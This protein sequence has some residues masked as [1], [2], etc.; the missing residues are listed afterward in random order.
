MRRMH[1]RLRGGGLIAALALASPHGGC[2][3]DGTAF[4]ITASAV[5]PSSGPVSGG[6]TIRITGDGFV[7]DGVGP[8]YVL[9]GG[10]LATAVTVLSD[11][12][13]EVVTPA[14]DAPG[15]APIVVA[16]RWG[17][18]TLDGYAFNAAPT[19]L[20]VDPPR[21]PTTGGNE[22]TLLGTG[23]A[24]AD[25]G[26]PLVYFGDA[27]ALSATVVD[28]GTVVAVPPTGA[29]FSAVPVTVRNRN[30]ESAPRNYRY[31]AGGLAVGLASGGSMTFVLIDVSVDPVTVTTSPPQFPAG[32]DFRLSTLAIHDGQLV[33]SDRS[34]V[35]TEFAGG[36]RVPLGAQS[37]FPTSLAWHQGALYTYSRQD[38]GLRRAAGY[39]GPFVSVGGTSPDSGNSL[40]S[41]GEHLWFMAGKS[42]WEF[43][44]ETG[45]TRVDTRI[46]FSNTGQCADLV[47]YEGALYGLCNYNGWGL[48]R[49]DLETASAQRLYTF[50]SVSTPH[51][52]VVI[53]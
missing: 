5:S 45:T 16:N 20:E 37:P 2:E 4:E 13:L 11:T 10:H 51:G 9:V 28:D 47:A 42:L 33:G 12:E 8:T 14:G 49:L 53:P 23:F 29:D 48:D 31:G 25:A 39:A 3:D 46:D 41:D 40:A 17:T 26:E 27:R 18:A 50:T 34:G 24:D 19:V 30:G 44:L 21:G 7:D 36:Q 52:M 32:G 1:Q 38:G 6:A 35:F 43:D 15:P 22:V